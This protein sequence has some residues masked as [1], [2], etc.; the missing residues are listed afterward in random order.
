MLRSPHIYI[1]FYMYRCHLHRVYI[2]HY[3][4][5]GIRVKT[6]KHIY[7]L[8]LITSEPRLVADPPDVKAL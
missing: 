3:V 4:R 8:R 5:K 7:R 1:K 2:Y 6:K